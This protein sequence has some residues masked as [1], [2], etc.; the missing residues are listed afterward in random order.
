MWSTGVLGG[1]KVHPWCKGQPGSTF[2]LL[3]YF[4][5]DFSLVYAIEKNLGSGEENIRG[6]D[7]QW[8]IRWAGP[9]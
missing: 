6:G 7:K 2:G 9:L 1:H 3:T 5:F 4:L 8:S